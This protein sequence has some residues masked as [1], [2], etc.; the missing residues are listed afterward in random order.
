MFEKHYAFCHEYESK[1]SKAI[2]ATGRG[3]LQDCEMLRIQIV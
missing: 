2:P 1:V 3:D